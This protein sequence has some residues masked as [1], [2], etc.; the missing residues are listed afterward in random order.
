MVAPALSTYDGGAD[1]DHIVVL[2]DATWA[3]Y[4][5]LLEM[6]GDHSAPR[7]AYLEGELEIMSPSRTHGAVKSVIGRLIEVW[8]FERGVEFRNLGVVDSQGQR[9]AAWCR[10]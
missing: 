6:R 1:H 4:E 8:C 2:H 10:A 7:F 9:C 5:R 3:D